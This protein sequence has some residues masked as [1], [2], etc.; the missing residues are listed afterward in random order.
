[1][2]PF[3]G[4][5]FQNHYTTHDRL[6]FASG[7]SG[8]GLL[9]DRPLGKTGMDRKGDFGGSEKF[10][11]PFRQKSFINHYFSNFGDPERS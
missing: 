10:W 3:C 1:M 8:P 11:G 6:Y 9:G 4:G 7:P 5:A 2:A